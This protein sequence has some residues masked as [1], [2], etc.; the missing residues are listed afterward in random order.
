MKA[1]VRCPTVNLSGTRCG[2]LLLMVDST[3]TGRL[4]CKCGRCKQET[5]QWSS[6]VGMR[7]AVR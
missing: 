2:K 5:I 7:S 4:Y 1:Q 6:M 3:A